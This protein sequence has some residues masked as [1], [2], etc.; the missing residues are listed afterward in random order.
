MVLF[1]PKF[2]EPPTFTVVPQFPNLPPLPTSM[3]NKP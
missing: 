1:E 2:T 3:L